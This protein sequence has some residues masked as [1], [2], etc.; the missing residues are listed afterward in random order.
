MATEC[1]RVIL[2]LTPEKLKQ[3][4]HFQGLLMSSPCGPITGV[5][6]VF[7]ED[8][9]PAILSDTKECAIQLDTFEEAFKQLKQ[10]LVS[11]TTL[12]SVLLVQKQSDGVVRPIAFASR[13]L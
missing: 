5:Y 3:L 1:R 11:A 9:W 4:W 6:S 13:T 12:A 7:L 8:C 10:A 2:L